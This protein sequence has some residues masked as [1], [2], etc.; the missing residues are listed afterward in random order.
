[1]NEERILWQ[2][3][4]GCMV[5]LNWA[6]LLVIFKV[7]RKLYKIP[8]KKLLSKREGSLHRIE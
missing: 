1:M 6:A 5:K 2:T 8:K 3:F 4:K 7:P